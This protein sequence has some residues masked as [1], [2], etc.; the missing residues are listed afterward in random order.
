MNRYGAMARRHWTRWLPG[1]V[2]A[3]DDPNSFFST[4]GDEVATEIEAVTVGLAGDDPPGEDYL[5]KVGRLNM[6][7][8]QAEERVLAERVLLTPEPG[9]DSEEDEPAEPETATPAE[10]RWVP[11][12]EDPDNPW[13]Q[14]ATQ[15]ESSR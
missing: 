3:M 12:V 9:T 6:A 5:T 15:E 2:E 8:L 13:W 10:G 14:Q 4:L 7:R 1:R 11:L